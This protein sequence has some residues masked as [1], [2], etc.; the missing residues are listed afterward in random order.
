MSTWV[1]SSALPSAPRV[2]TV[3]A[4]AVPVAGQYTLGVATPMSSSVE[5]DGY[6]GWPGVVLDAGSGVDTADTAGAA[7]RSRRGHVVLQRGGESG[8]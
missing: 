4:P 6:E 8:P 1:G 3:S 5:R 7:A 2:A